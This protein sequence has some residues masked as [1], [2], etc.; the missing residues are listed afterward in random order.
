MATGTTSTVHQLRWNGEGVV[1]VTPE[2]SDRF[3][4]KLHRAI[5]VLQQADHADEFKR[6]FNLLLCVLAGWLK[7][8]SDI[9]RAFLTHRD[10]VLAFVVVRASCEYDDDFEDALSSLDFSVA[11]DADLDRI[12]MDAITLPPASDSAIRSFLAPGFVIEY[13]GNGDRGGSHSAGE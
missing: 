5:E 13:I 2:D 10:G 11:N 8:R 3:G 12:K 1:I 6:Q 7:D 4:V 9:D